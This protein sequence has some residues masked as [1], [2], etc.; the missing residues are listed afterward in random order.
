MA[1]SIPTL[2]AVIVFAV[3]AA[4]GH[5]QQPAEIWTT[6]SMLNLLRMPLM[7]LPKYI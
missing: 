5:S 3:Y 6:L 1:I 7:A 2:A 4:T